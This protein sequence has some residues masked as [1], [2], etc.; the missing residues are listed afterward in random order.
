[1][2]GFCSNGILK[3]PVKLILKYADDTNLLVPKGSDANILNKFEA[4]RNWTRL[5]KMQFNV[6]KTRT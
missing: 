5:N 6:K 4:I 3:S 1:V 2:Q